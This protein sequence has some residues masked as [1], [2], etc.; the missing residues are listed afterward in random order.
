LQKLSKIIVLLLCTI[1]VMGVVLAETL[2]TLTVSNTMRLTLSTQLELRNGAGTAVTS[3]AWGDFA[4]N[5]LKR[6]DSEVGDGLMHLYNL[7]NG[8]VN[9]QWT[10]NCPAG[11]QLWLVVDGQTWTSG[12]SKSIPI[13]GHLDMEINMR[14]LTANGGQAYTYDL[15]FN[16]VS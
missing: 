5:G 2:Y 15:N 9:V 12:T 1:A 7:G 16:V 11:W 13:G 3:Y 6:M 10:S 4:E 8:A 14:E